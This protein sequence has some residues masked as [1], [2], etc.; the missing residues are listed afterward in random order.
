MTMVFS[1]E[2][3]EE[4]LQE[5]SSRLTVIEASLTWCRPCI[6]FERTFEARPLHF[7]PAAMPCP[8]AAF[9]ACADHVG[10]T[11]SCRACLLAALRAHVPVRH[12]T[13]ILDESLWMCCLSSLHPE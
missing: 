1:A 2:E 3:L 7:M 13:V 12:C 11:S 10:S 6:A 8:A 5:N 9:A 4:V